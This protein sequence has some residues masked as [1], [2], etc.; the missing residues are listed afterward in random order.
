MAVDRGVFF[1]QRIDI[2]DGDQDPDGAVLRGLRD[3]ELIEIARVVVVD[4]RPLEAAK[5]AELGAGSRRSRCD[6]VGLGDDGSGKVR[7]Q[8]ALLHRVV[9]DPSQRI[10]VEVVSCRHRARRSWD[11]RVCAEV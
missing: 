6:A 9:R 11:R 2:R 4:R 3:R 5:V 7:E 1:H 8:P 10:S